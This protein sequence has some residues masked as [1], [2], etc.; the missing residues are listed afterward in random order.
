[1]NKDGLF[2]L[3]CFVTTIFFFLCT[4]TR[5][6]IFQIPGF[7]WCMHPHDHRVHKLGLGAGVLLSGMD[8]QQLCSMGMV[9]SPVGSSGTGSRPGWGKWVSRRAAGLGSWS[10]LVLAHH[11]DAVEQIKLMHLNLWAILCSRLF[12]REF[13]SNSLETIEEVLLNMM[14]IF[15]SKYLLFLSLSLLP[16]YNKNISQNFKGINCDFS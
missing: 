7:V 5:Q 2:C 14:F 13:L 12:F 9:L 3:E 10:F 11:Q 1:M 16:V 4:A 6:G 8:Q 15:I